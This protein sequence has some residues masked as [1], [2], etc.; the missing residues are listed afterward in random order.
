MTTKYI[1]FNISNQNDF[2][3]SLNNRVQTYFIE[4]NIDKQYNGE[5]VRKTI[6]MIGLYFIP[7]GLMLSGQFTHPITL[8]LLWLTMA[9]G[10]AGIGL[11]IMH[12]A[13]HGAYSKNSGINNLFGMIIHFLGVSQLNWKIQHNVLH[14][15]YTNI[16]GYDDSLHAGNL[17][18]FSPHQPLKKHHRLQ[19]YYGWL[20]YSLQTL[21]W[22]IITDFVRLNNYNKRGLTASR[23]K[24]NFRL[25]TELILWKLFYFGFILVLP[26]AVL[27]TPWWWTLLFFLAMQLTAGFILACIF[28]PAHVMPECN[29]PLPDNNGNIANSWAIHQLQTSCNF[30]TQSRWFS[31]FVGG[32][33][34]QIEHHIFPN[35]CHVHYPPISKLLKQTALEYNLPYYHQS[36]FLKAVIEHGKMLKRLGRP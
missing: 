25:M 6:F 33:N 20:L 9:I 14:H 26:M 7:Y 5:M 24:S 10:M 17:L 36:T 31:W 34:F 19:H 18:R 3:T 11:G 13:N 22:A 35:I 16:E 30:A 32:L 4:N 28:L 29:Y 21:V 23:N 2:I 15:T 1:K 8:L 27:S 12:D